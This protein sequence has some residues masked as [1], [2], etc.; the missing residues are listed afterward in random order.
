MKT[1]TIISLHSTKLLDRV[2]EAIRYKHYSASTEQVYVYWC[3]FFIRFHQLR[4]PKDMGASEV[5]AFL[6][7]LANEKR[8]STSTHK[9]ALA[10]L[11]FMYKNVLHIDLPWL[12]EIG[13][14]RSSHRLPV[15]LSKEDLSALFSHLSGTY[16]LL[17]KLLYGTGMRINEALNLRVKDLDL[18]H[19]VIT[20]RE[21]KGGKDRPV[22][23]PISLLD[24]LNAQLAFA[25]SMWAK[26]RGGNLPGVR[27]PPSVARLYPTAGQ[28]WPWYWVFPQ[29]HC[30]TDTVAGS[31][32]REP[33]SDS[34]FQRA[35]K[36]AKTQAGIDSTATPHTMRHSFATHLLQSGCDIR[37][38][39]ELLG[40]ADL[41]TT[42]I[43]THVIN[44][45]GNARSPL[46]SL[47]D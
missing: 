30:T 15:V 6:S 47:Y 43:Y 20:I 37:T 13:R 21:G 24:L 46:D 8:V 7:Y 33:L 10:A 39:Q 42:M 2:K 11:L 45:S 40:H 14:P 27:L 3:R 31:V 26:D 17:A 1:D 28:T 5:E 44:A 32:H 29:A 18:S 9:Q 12:Q 41:S 22:M 16:L 36:I 23:L 34:T 25:N 38:V 35:F 19:R 4:H